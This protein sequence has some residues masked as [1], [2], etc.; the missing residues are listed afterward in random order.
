MVDVRK[1][2]EYI[3][4]LWRTSDGSHVPLSL[5]ATLAFHEA[6]DGAGAS[7]PEPEY[8]NALDLAAAALSRLLTVYTID[9]HTRRPVSAPVSLATGRFRYGATVYE[10]SN[11][12]ATTSLMVQ[13]EEVAAAME[14]IKATGIPFQFDSDI[15]A[16]LT[17]SR[18]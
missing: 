16:G 15:P 5:A 1:D 7:M 11:G 18:R 10:H 3:R 6:H 9:Q 8:D 14:V 12:R 4:E 13:R 17:P 2:G